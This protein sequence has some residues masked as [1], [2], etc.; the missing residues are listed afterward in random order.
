MLIWYIADQADPNNPQPNGH[1]WG[2]AD[3]KLEY[4]WTENNLMPQELIDILVEEE[5]LKTKK[6][7]RKKERAMKLPI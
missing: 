4:Q 6:M 1:G 2:I 7:E 3:G 5:D